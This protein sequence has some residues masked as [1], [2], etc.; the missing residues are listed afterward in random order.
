MKLSASELKYI[1]AL[2]ADR[3]V[4]RKAR[5]ISLNDEQFVRFQTECESYGLAPNKVIDAPIG[6]F[7]DSRSSR[8]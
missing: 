1:E 6:L 7:L 3:P 2:G 8:E 4:T 5:N